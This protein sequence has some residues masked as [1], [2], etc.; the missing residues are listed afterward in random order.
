MTTT[1]KLRGM[2]VALVTPFT[3]DASEVDYEALT[4]HINN[5]IEAGVHG[6]V[7]N[8]STGEFTALTFDE[9][10]AVVEACVK[11]AD[12]R[13]PVIAGTGAL[14]TKE[15][16]E[17]SKHAAEVGA[18]GVM[19]VPPFYDSVN[20]DELRG[21]LQEVHEVS[22]LPIMYY[23]IPS[24][25][26]LT[27]TAQELADLSEVPGVE[28]IKDTSGNADALTEL[29]VKH[30]D[31]ITT[32][33]GWDTLTFVG[34]ASGAKG[35][36]W[37]AINIFPELA[38]ELWN[39]IAERKDLDKGRAIWA[40]LWP[41]VDYI[42][43]FNYAAGIKAGMNLVGRPAGPVRAPFKPLSDNDLKPLAELLEQAGLPVV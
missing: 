7:P 14:T 35:S 4:T 3:P 24:A 38:V 42:D 11:A 29:L 10:L 19:I 41:I 23:N 6:L 13:V 39:A 8:G 36:V 31:R 40:K 20:V 25:S 18:A 34:I 5:L 1:T 30:S 26:G 28:Y 16:L 43:N 32:F 12:G 9:R 17:Y 37:G 15:T 2:L 33:N 21:L 27:L 22:G